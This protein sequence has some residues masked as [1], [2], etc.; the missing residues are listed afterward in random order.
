ML[1]AE[2]HEGLGE[3][4]GVRAGLGGTAVVGEAG[5]GIVHRLDLVLFG[6]SESLALLGEHMDDD[7]PVELGGVLE[8][9]FHRGDVVTVEGAHV[10]DAEILEERRRLPHLAH[11]RFRHAHATADLLA[12]PGDALGD[13]LD[14]GLAAHI[15]R[16][17]ADLHQALG[18]SRDGGG[19]GAT[20]VV[21][22]D[23][24]VAAGMAEIVEALEGHAAGH[25]AVADH[26]HD[27]STGI[28]GLEGR[29]EPVGVAQDGR[30]VGVLDPVVLGLAAVRVA[31]QAAALAQVG[32]V[33]CSAG[34]DLV[35]VRLVAGVPEDEVMGR[36]EDPVQR[37][38]ELDGTE[39][40]SEM[41]TVVV[42]RVDDQLANLVG[43]IVKLLEGAAAKVVRPAEGV[44]Q[45]HPEGY[46]SD[47][48]RAGSGGVQPS[49]RH[50]GRSRRRRHQ[51]RSGSP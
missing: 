28:G 36:P 29:G 48:A 39:I 32:E 27:A 21:E 13:L 34:E 23:R 11:R 44:E 25:G 9:L 1:V 20:V 40:R 45:H 51:A 10:A 8:G 38:R 5:L 4:C 17:V 26:R 35:H 16:V 24:D 33:A 41:A 12:D 6:G 19:V 3:R 15:D 18:Q 2:L 31:G 37:D 46:R 7:R 43:E 14:L 47:P 30:C 50:R 49:G 42:H 22:N